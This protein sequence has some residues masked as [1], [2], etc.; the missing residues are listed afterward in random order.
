[1]SAALGL[2]QIRR[3]P[4]S[5]EKR[6]LVAERY[7]ELLEPYEWVRRRSQPGRSLCRSTTI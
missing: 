7:H 4:E 5:L 2:S 1:M 3:L 6:R